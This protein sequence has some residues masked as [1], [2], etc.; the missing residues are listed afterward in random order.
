MSN[1]APTSTVHSPLFRKGDRALWVS[2]RQSVII[3]SDPIP[4]VDGRV[5]V[6]NEG[7]SVM[8]PDGPVF[9]PGVTVFMYEVGPPF[10]GV[11]GMVVAMVREDDLKMVEA[12]VGEKDFGLI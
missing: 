10:V 6:M 5:P 4:I 1:N 7:V 12:G 11:D 2:Q 9:T 8:G 3:T